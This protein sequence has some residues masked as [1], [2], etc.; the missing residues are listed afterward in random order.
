MSNESPGFVED[1]DGDTQVTRRDFLKGISAGL[2]LAA[3]GLD[4]EATSVGEKD[5]SPFDPEVQKKALGFVTEKMGVT[6]DINIVP[7]PTVLEA[8]SVSDA[9]FNE[10]IGFD[11][12]GKRQNLFLPPCTILLVKRSKMHNLVHE[13]VHYIQYNYKGLTDGTTDEVENQAVAIQNLFRE[14]DP[15]VKSSH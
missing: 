2:A 1:T 10:K 15:E 14:N 12:E 7:L 9:D 8:E 11:T 5:G 6:L 13:C 4:S 3:L